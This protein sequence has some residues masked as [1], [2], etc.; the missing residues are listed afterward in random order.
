MK[1]ITKNNNNNNNNDDLWSTQ[2][3]SSFASKWLVQWVL[4]VYTRN[5]IKTMIKS[6]AHVNQVI[7][8]V[9]AQRFSCYYKQWK[10]KNKIK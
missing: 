8:L 2:E 1:G 3:D 10:Q 5:E 6:F 7:V 4:Q 9:T